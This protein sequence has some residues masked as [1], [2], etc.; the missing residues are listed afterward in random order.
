MNLLR[1]TGLMA[2]A[3]V[4]ALGC[5]PDDSGVG[6]GTDDSGS[7][8]GSDTTA[9]PTTNGTNPTSTTNTSMGATS[10]T[11]M[12]DSSSGD[13][14]TTAATTDGPGTTTGESGESSSGD[15]PGDA[16]PPCM[17]VGECP[18]PYDVCWP[19][20]GGGNFCSVECM[21]A[22][23]CPEPT[24]GDAVPVCEGPPGG[25]QGCVLDCSMG[26]CPDGMDCVDIFGDG[27]FLRCIHP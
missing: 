22:G 20:F 5:G 18:A 19:P 26:T 10:S 23:E 9:G 3:L 7:G 13:D 6:G 27:A 2:S 17:D 16:Y 15:P 25:V 4:L 1:T 12:A 14:A 21:D 11:G 8:S 24:S